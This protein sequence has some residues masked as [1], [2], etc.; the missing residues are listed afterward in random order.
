MFGFCS[1]NC[2]LDDWTRVNFIPGPLHPYLSPS[3]TGVFRSWSEN[4]PENW[5]FNLSNSA[6]KRIRPT[7][8]RLHFSNYTAMMIITKLARFLPH[9]FEDS[10]M[11]SY[12]R[13]PLRFGTVL[14]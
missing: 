5:L 13:T 6:V 1:E 12:S 2:L 7:R 4:H 8:A 14:A 10:F 11:T 3:N 9:R